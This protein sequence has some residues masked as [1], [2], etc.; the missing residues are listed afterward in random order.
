MTVF[1]FQA[2]GCEASFD[3]DEKQYYPM[4][5]NKKLGEIYEKHAKALGFTFTDD[6][7]ALTGHTGMYIATGSIEG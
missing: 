1:C 5:H 2:T 7:E 3:V 6:V 4:Q